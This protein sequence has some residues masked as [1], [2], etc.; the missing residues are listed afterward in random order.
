MLE[1]LNHLG[2]IPQKDITV[3][4]VL[5]KLKGLIVWGILLAMNGLY[6]IVSVVASLLSYTF[7]EGSLTIKKK[8][9]SLFWDGCIY[10]MN[11]NNVNIEITGDAMTSESAIFLSNHQSL[12][13]HIVINYLAK[14]THLVNNDIDAPTVNFFTWF[15][16]WKVP[17]LRILLNLA[18]N[19]ENWELDPNLNEIFFNKLN[20]KKTQW[21]VLFP[22]V[23]IYTKMSS[24][25]QKIQCQRFYLPVFQN[26]LYPRFSSFYNVM[27]MNSKIRFN[28]LYDLTICYYKTV[29]HQKQYFQPTLLQIFSD[30]DPI[31]VTIDVKFKLLS[32]VSLNRNKLEKWLEKTWIDKDNYLQQLYSSPST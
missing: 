15:L 1:L 21:L 30:P 20:Y 12:V 29:D 9:Y 26:V 3:L 18:K 6:Q 10:F 13:D 17:T 14:Y 4:I 5:E 27:N 11:M 23:N 19:D 2:L 28:K 7:P 16:I 8:A 25:I 32:K 31:F 22:E 24:E